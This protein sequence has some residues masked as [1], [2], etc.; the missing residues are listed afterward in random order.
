MEKE[1]LIIADESCED[2]RL[3]KFIAV[4]YEDLSRSYIQ[5]LMTDNLV[6]VNDRI[7]KPS[8]R[9]CE[10]DRIRLT[11]PES[12]IPDI[13]PDDIPLDIIFE[14][15][16]ILIVNKPKNMVVHP[17]AGNYTGTLVNALMF[18]CKDALSG[19]NGCLRPGIVHR[20]DKDTTGLLVV[21]KNDIAHRNVAAQLKEHSINRRYEAICIGR[22][23]DSKGTIDAPIGR[24]EKDRKKMAINPRNGKNAVTHYEVIEELKGFSHIYCVLETGRTHQIRVHLSSIGHPLLGDPLYGGER[25]G[26]DT[27]GQCLHA[28]L[29]GLV[30]PR[31]GEYMEFSVPAPEY[32]RDILNKISNS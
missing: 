14:D 30:H 1:V 10:G 15:D 22:L 19:I 32:F 16:D 29:L 27:Q 13:I 11:V 26:W 2:Q 23:P 4:N 25:P 20:I 24:S 31:T 28:G 18:H 9:V 7:E 21:C 17:A 3:D 6:S 5:K 12:V 8:Y